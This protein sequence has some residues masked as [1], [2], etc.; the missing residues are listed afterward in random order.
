MFCTMVIGGSMLAQFYPLIFADKNDLQDS[1][2]SKEAEKPFLYVSEHRP[3][4]ENLAVVL[5]MTEEALNKELVVLFA[6]KDW[7]TDFLRVSADVL[8]RKLVRDNPQQTMMLLHSKTFA[9]AS[10][11]IKTLSVELIFRYLAYY[12]PNCFGDVIDALKREN[13]DFYKYGIL[14]FYS[15]FNETMKNDLGWLYA[16][17]TDGSMD[18]LFELMCKDLSDEE[19]FAKSFEG[20]REWLWQQLI[21]TMGVNK[22]DMFLA[23]LNKLPKK[24]WNYER[25]SLWKSF[26]SGITEENAPEVFAWA[27]GYLSK[28]DKEFFAKSYFDMLIERDA[29]S[30]EIIYFVSSIDKE[31]LGD[32]YIENEIESIARKDPSGAIDLIDISLD[33][34]EREVALTEVVNILNERKSVQEMLPIINDLSDGICKNNIAQP[35]LEKYYAEFPD[36]AVVWVREN[37]TYRMQERL[38]K[39]VQGEDYE[40]RVVEDTNDNPKKT[41]R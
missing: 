32:L 6:K 13:I 17:M 19:R 41:R 21:A 11:T 18:D 15:F 8:L 30:R 24:G 25:Y 37:F 1:L 34:Y 16:Y 38:L 2:D 10:E 35:F 22:R 4:T 23:E 36:D 26:V 9:D 12:Y 39:R 14:A 29:D 28:K 27:M 5:T 33:G 40:P 7:N 31:L 20:Y 3:I